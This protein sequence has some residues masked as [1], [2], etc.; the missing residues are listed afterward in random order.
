MFVGETG[1]SRIVERTCEVMKSVGSDVAAVRAAGAIDLPLIQR[2][3]NL[4]YSLTLDLFG[5]EIS[6]NAA[7]AFNAGI[8]GRYREDKLTDDHELIGDTYKVMRFIDG[9]IVEQEAPALS[10][11]NMRLRDDFIADA[12]GGVGRWNKVIEKAGIDFRLTLPHQ[13]HNR[14]IGEFK[15]IEAD[16]LG[17]ILSA[18]EWA[19][20]KDAFLPTADDAAFILGLMQP[21]HKV[22]EYASW[23]APPKMGIDGKPGDYEYVMIHA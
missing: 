5:N 2:K 17:N 23:I 20:R 14:H 18:E 16:T 7:N 6:T 15:V 1:V 8:K 19:A 3:I 4:H 10:A 12:A 9:A 22:G 13:A 21:V 11:L